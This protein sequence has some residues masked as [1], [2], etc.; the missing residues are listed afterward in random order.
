MKGVDDADAIVQNRSLILDQR[1]RGQSPITFPNAHRTACRMKP[2]PDFGCRCDCIV[3]ATTVGIKV[4]VIRAQRTTRQRQFCQTDLGRDKHMFRR[5]PRPDRIERLQP[6][7]QQRILRGRHRTGHRLVQMVVRVH[8][9]RRHHTTLCQHHLAGG[10]QTAAYFGDQ[11]IADQNIG[12]CQFAPVVVHGHDVGRV[13][14]Q[15]F[16]HC[17]PCKILSAAA[18]ISV[19]AAANARPP[20]CTAAPDQ[21]VTTPP[22]ASITAMG[23]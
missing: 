21:S 17:V 15:P 4:Q 10:L 19:L 18:W 20:L 1:V 6:P 8:E 22:A 9:A 5:E 3:E 2:Q 13:A 14:D 7:K 11:A 23:A 16:I 12:L